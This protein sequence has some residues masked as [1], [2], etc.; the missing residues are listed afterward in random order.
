MP[1]SQ[2]AIERLLKPAT[3][4]PQR[5]E[6]PVIIQAATESQPERILTYTQ[7]ER[8][9]DQSTALLEEHK[10]QP[11]Q[12]VLYCSENSSELAAS[13]LA[14]WRLGAIAVPVDSR[15]TNKELA[16]IANQL[17]AKLVMV[18]PRVV[19]D[20][21]SFQQ[22]LGNHTAL[23]DLTTL[24]AQ[25]RTSQTVMAQDLSRPALL[26][27]TSGTTGMPKA[28]VHDL[29]S[30]IVNLLEL[31]SMA[32]INE[33][34][35]GVL[36]L[37]LSHIFGLEVFLI[38][39]IYG[40]LTVFCEI[41]P[42]SFLECLRKHKP[43][44][45]VGVPTIYASLLA[46]PR[47]MLDLDQAE[48][49][50]CGGAPLPLSLAEEFKDKFGKRLNNGYG[51]TESKIVAL[52][53]HGPY[54]SVGQIVPSAKI[55][56][57][58]DKDEPLPEGETGEIRIGGPTL[59][60]G[61]LQQKEATDR[62]LRNGFY[63][64]GDMG[65][66]KDQYLYIAGRSKEMIIVAGFKVFPAEVEDALRCHPLVAEV[67]VLGTPHRQLGQIVRAV[68]VIKD[69]ELSRKLEGSGEDKK[70]ARQELLAIFKEY[71]KE[72]L[73]RELRPMEWEFQ[74]ASQ[75]LPKMLTGKIDKKNLEVARV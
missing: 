37:P 14:S 4:Q 32:G 75:P 59:M 43:H 5:N 62:V 42:T 40:M 51:S 15:I 33:G 7:F 31:G 34:K 56:I 44:V 3:A 39:V 41:T 35:R 26:I 28:A 30:L 23:F 74:P 57:V 71:S 53:L 48:T 72:H 18:S 12:M 16:N 47:Q 55:E 8:L 45:L 10:I 66:I 49:L 58:N 27:L 22:L 2:E 73:R 65:Y 13:I 67:A 36:P 24:T 61:Y 52:N 9:V 25:A 17:S 64:T 70:A 11:G 21:A 63:Y 68:L 50:L 60:R 29:Q 19:P 1:T 20:F 38:S 54:E 46:V 6:R 69:P